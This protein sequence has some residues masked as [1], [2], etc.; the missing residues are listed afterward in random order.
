MV[1]IV[2]IVIFEYKTLYIRISLAAY[3]ILDGVMMTVQY[4]S[5]VMP[6]LVVLRYAKVEYVANRTSASNVLTTLV[7]IHGDD[8]NVIQDGVARTAIP[9]CPHTVTH[10]VRPAM[11]LQTMSAIPVLFIV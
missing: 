11:A 4:S 5:Q 8:A 2:Q 7:L 3:V 1:R 10:D 9:T 6:K